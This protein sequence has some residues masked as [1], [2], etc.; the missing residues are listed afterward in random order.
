MSSYSLI[1]IKIELFVALALFLSSLPSYA[2]VNMDGL[3]FKSDSDSFKADLDVLLSGSSGNSDTQSI[4]VN[5]QFSWFTENHINLAVLGYQ[6]RENENVKSQD[7]S[8]VHFRHIRKMTSSRD[9][10]I[11]SQA[12]T[13]QFTRLSYRGLLGTG[14]RYSVFTTENHK[15][16]AG[17]GAFYLREKVEYRAG[18]TDHGTDEYSRANFY[19]LS[20]YKTKSKLNFTNV[21][22]FQPRLGEFSDYNA[23]IESKLDVQIT[24]AFSLRFAVDIEY[25]SKP[26]QTIEKMD[27]NYMTGFVYRI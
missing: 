6:Y 1:N 8:F 21:L 2:I 16:Y 18:L 14:L 27:V 25:D 4:S 5:S 20:K 23:L 9:W 26:S 17:I 11:F 10:E 3:H 19:L 13:N 7:K 24:P 15:S 12:E 22:Y